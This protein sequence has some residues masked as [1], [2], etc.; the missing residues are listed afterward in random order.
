MSN[1]RVFSHILICKNVEKALEQL[2]EQ[3]EHTRHL[4][5]HKDE[6]LMDDA[7]EVIKEAYIAESSDKYLILAA[8]SYRIEAQNA[9]LKIL[10]EPPHHIVFVV[11][12]PS[13]TTLLPTIRSRLPHQELVVTQ[14]RVM[15]DLPLNRLDL[16]DIYEYVQAHQSIEKNS[17]KE[18]VQAIIYEA[19]HRFRLRFSEKELEHFQKLL[20][21][22]ELNSRAQTVLTSLLLS[23][24]LRTYR[25]TL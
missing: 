14:E 9:L 13:K 1:E 6:F 12:A 3:F 21:L 19:I 10:E 16:S 17:L 2:E 22:A 4:L 15:I 11:V 8:K 25:E 5:F 20:H 23:I 18:L 24:M 7:K